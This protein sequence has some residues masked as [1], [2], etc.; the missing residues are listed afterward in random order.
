MLVSPWEDW[1]VVMPVLASAKPG[2]LKD[3][4]IAELFS[5]KDPE[6]RYEDL[7]EI[8]HGSFGAVFFVSKIN[9]F[10][11]NLVGFRHLIRKRRKLLLS[12]KWHFLANKQM[13]NGQ[14]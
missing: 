1:N 12:R 14:I 10:Y 2:S 9:H 5:T 13:K 8:G 4:E 3:P 11:F 7:R 6:L